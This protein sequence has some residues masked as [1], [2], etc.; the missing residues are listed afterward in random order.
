MEGSPGS[1]VVRLFRVRMRVIL[2][3]P[4]AAGISRYEDVSRAS[5]VSMKLSWVPA[6]YDRAGN[7][8]RLASGPGVTTSTPAQQPQGSFIFHLALSLPADRFRESRD[9]YQAARFPWAPVRARS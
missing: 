9:R 6:R 1:R 4:S 2:P 7:P 5:M 3:L 8:G